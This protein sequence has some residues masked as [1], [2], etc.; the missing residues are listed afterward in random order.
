MAGYACRRGGGMFLY[1]ASTPTL[2][3][4]Y[5][6]GYGGGGGGGGGGGQEDMMKGN[7][8]WSLSLLVTMNQKREANTCHVRKN[9]P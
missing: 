8:Q 2:V 6:E 4:L 7:M 1:L 9:M 5:I 3:T